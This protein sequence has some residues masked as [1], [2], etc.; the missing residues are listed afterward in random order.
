MNP[1][2]SCFS[3]HLQHLQCGKSSPLARTAGVDTL[4]SVQA[5][6]AVDA[7][8]AVCGAGQSGYAEQHEHTIPR[9]GQ[10]KQHERKQ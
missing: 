6:V 5:D 2:I 7:M 10:D 9:L 3:L 8:L 4:H 1:M